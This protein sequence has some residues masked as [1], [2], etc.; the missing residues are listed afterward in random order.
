MA[1]AETKSISK[2]KKGTLENSR[3]SVDGVHNPH[4]GQPMTALGGLV[5]ILGQYKERRR[6]P[7]RLPSSE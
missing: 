3:K 6:R 1:E 7:R 2:S 5:T 4:A